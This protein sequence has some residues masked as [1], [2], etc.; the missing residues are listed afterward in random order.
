M[1]LA[2]LEDRS[3]RNNLKIRGIP[4][5]ISAQQLPNFA[6]DL[7][8]TVIPS[9][10]PTDLTIDRIHRVPKPTFLPQEVPRDVLLRVHFFQIKEKILHAFR[11]ADNLPDQA[12]NLQVLPDLSQY[13]LQQRR[14][15]ATLTKA[16]RNHKIIT[17]NTWPNSASPTKAPITLLTPLRKA[18][19]S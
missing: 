6:C 7:F 18:S 15:L 4:K 19:T 8:Q 5:S 2:D 16:L 14:N 12:A 11:T 10:S 9:L 3:R 1:K 13:T 17:R